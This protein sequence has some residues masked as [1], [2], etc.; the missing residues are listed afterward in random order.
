MEMLRCDV[1]DT[2]AE[3][4]KHPT[5]SKLLLCVRKHRGLVSA[6][7]VTHKEEYVIE[8]LRR[9]VLTSQWKY[10]VPVGLNLFI[11]NL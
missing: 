2:L 4:V 7:A 3:L 5:L 9:L 8:G 6:E 1:F 11:S 10:I